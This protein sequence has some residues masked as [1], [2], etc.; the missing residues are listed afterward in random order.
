MD[1]SNRRNNPYI[2]KVVD[3]SYYLKAM[4]SD[5][6]LALDY[7]LHRVFNN[8]DVSTKLVRTNLLELDGRK[9]HKRV[10]LEDNGEI[11]L[12]PNFQNIMIGIL[13]KI[14]DKKQN[15]RSSLRPA[16][17]W[18]LITHKLLEN[19]SDE[20]LDNL[21]D[22]INTIYNFDEPSEFGSLIKV[23][24]S[25]WKAETRRDIVTHMIL[26]EFYDK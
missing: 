22:E 2:S 12:D 19:C 5:D 3:T 17:A 10:L 7:K 15:A 18:F 23:Y 14:D 26:G 4:D 25:R 20:L 21:K 16:L 13:N 6:L 8:P 1:N 11:M 9:T 24:K